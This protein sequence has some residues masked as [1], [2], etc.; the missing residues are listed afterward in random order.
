MTVRQLRN[1]LEN[2]ADETPVL[3]YNEN[4]DLLEIYSVGGIGVNTSIDID[5]GTIYRSRLW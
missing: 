5:P 4:D 1:S 2:M 3:I